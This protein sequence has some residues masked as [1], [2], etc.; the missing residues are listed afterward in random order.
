MKK[1]TLFFALLIAFSTVSK[2]QDYSFRFLDVSAESVYQSISYDLTLQCSHYIEQNV[3]ADPMMIINLETGDEY[4]FVFDPLGAVGSCKMGYFHMPDW[5]SITEHGTYMLLIPAGYF[6]VTTDAGDVLSEEIVVSPLYVGELPKLAYVD[7]NPAN[8]SAV[9][10]LNEISVL[11]N[12]GILPPNQIEFERPLTIL[13]KDNNTV[14]SITFVM[15]ESVTETK[16]AT[17]TVDNPITV[18]GEYSL[19]IPA[20]YCTAA[21]GDKH[22]EITLSF[23]VDGTYVDTAVEDVDAENGEQVIYDITG[24]RIKSIT[25]PGI[26]IVNGKKVLVK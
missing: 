19:T 11:F 13:D 17:F 12:R 1:I 26:Y 25:A 5:G 23:V 9:Q 14:S 4:V 2:A 8:G 3:G 15:T 16:V 18:A 10:I 22:D 6:T 20:G 7:A 24:S 21:N